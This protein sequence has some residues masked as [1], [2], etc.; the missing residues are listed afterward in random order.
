MSDIEP[1]K[2]E[3]I[4]VFSVRTGTFFF[5][6]RVSS[7]SILT[8]Y[9]QMD[10]LANRW[11]NSVGGHAQIRSHMQSTHFGDVQ[12]FAIDD[13]DWNGM[14]R[15]IVAGATNEREVKADSQLLYGC[16]MDVGYCQL[17]MFPA[18]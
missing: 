18:N 1:P 2:F 4:R 11:R 12:Q 15:L 3:I 10:S 7:P 14:K 8:L 9:S 13:V 17:T 6:N 5:Y 16:Q